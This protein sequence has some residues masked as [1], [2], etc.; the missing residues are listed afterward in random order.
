MVAG[1]RLKFS[2]AQEQLKASGHPQ[3]PN[4]FLCQMCLVQL[5]GSLFSFPGKVGLDGADLPFQTPRKLWV[6]VGG[7]LL[8]SVDW[9]TGTCFHTTIQDTKLNSQWLI[10]LRTQK[11]G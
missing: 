1:S 3:L 7:D 2:G 11:L 10:L 9:Y 5:A 6:N 8:F 4:A